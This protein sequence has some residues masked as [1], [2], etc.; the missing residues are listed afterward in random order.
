PLWI[1][2]VDVHGM[3]A[4]AAYALERGHEVGH[5]ERHVMRTRAVT[6]EKPREEVLLVDVAGFQQLDRHSVALLG[7]EPYLHGPKADALAAEEDGAAERAG[8]VAQ[9]VGS[10]GCR[11]RDMVEVVAVGHE[12]GRL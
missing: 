7:A 8:E 5:L 12:S 9:R 10:V 6:G 3:K 1:G 4:G 11:E 2:N